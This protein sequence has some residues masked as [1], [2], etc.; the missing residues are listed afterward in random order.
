MKI[1]ITGA[2]GFIGKN[3]CAHLK[4]KGYNDLIIYTKKSSYEMLDRFGAEAD[5]VFHLAGVNR[6]NDEKGFEDNHIFTAKVLEC[7]KKH[8]NKAP[9]LMSSSIQ[10]ELNN[11]YGKSKRKAEQLLFEYAAETGTKVY[12]YRLP[13]VFG[14]W[15]RPNYNS[16]VA[17]FCDAIAYKRPINIDDADV[18]LRLAYIDDVVEEFIGAIKDNVSR[19]GDFCTIK[20]I[21]KLT[22]GD[23][24]DKISSFRE[25]R[26]NLMVVNTG[27]M[28]TRQ[29]YSTYLSYLPEDSFGYLLSTHTD[30]RGSFTEFLKSEDCGQISIN[31]AKPGVTRGNHWHQTKTEKL[32]VASGEGVICFQKVGEQKVYK[33]EVSG[34]TPKVVDVPVGYVHHI[35]NTGDSDMV[36]VIWANQ[37]FDPENPDTYPM[38]ITK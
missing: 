37:I 6:P 38:E 32:L 21:H 2:D 9:I 4:N 36:I 14:K 15:C 19:Q 27:D 17:T 13:G 24:A 16:V 34:C 18:V 26:H 22:V 20:P 28:L 33:Y 1:L 30:N 31:V 5:F 10:A 11:P 3:L 29:L 25:S 8:G 12:V 35:T 7:L 23:L